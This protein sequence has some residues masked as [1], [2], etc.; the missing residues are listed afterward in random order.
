LGAGAN[1]DADAT[2]G[3]LHRAKFFSFGSLLVERD[4]ERRTGREGGREHGLSG[5]RRRVG[6][7]HF[8]K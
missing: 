4:R 6:G 1:A 2:V 3:S 8:Q 5:A 7:S